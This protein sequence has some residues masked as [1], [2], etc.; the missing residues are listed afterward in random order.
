MPSGTTSQARALRN[1]HPG[2][3]PTSSLLLSLRR[4][5]RNCAGMAG[6]FS[7][8][9][10]RPVG[11]PVSQCPNSR[12]ARRRSLPPACLRWQGRSSSSRH[13]P[14]PIK[15]WMEGAGPRF[16]SPS[17]EALFSSTRRRAVPRTPRPPYEKDCQRGTHGQWLVG[18]GCADGAALAATRSAARLKDQEG[19]LKPWAGRAA[20]AHPGMGCGRQGPITTL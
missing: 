7:S 8:G 15:E 12:A 18:S 14:S 10:S 20:A 2:K 11:S 17:H 6:R 16:W 4:I 1:R 9:R 3:P 5:L 13:G 19:G